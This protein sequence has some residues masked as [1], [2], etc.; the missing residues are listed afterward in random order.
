MAENGN[1]LDN[2]ERFLNHFL[3]KDNER[4]GDDNEFGFLKDRWPLRSISGR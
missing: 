1:F 3:E 4:R 2:D